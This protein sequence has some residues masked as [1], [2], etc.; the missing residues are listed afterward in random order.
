MAATGIADRLERSVGEWLYKALLEICG[1]VTGRDEDNRGVNVSIESDASL[2]S[3]RSFLKKISR[4]SISFPNGRDFETVTAQPQYGKPHDIEVKVAIKYFYRQLH[5]SA[6]RAG[7]KNALDRQNDDKKYITIISDLGL[8]REIYSARELGELIAITMEKYANDD[9]DVDNDIKIS[10]NIRS[11]RNGLICIVTRERALVLKDAG[12]LQCPVRFCTKWA[13]GEKGMWWHQRKEHNAEH[14][15]AVNSACSISNCRAIVVFNPL[16]FSLDMWLQSSTEGCKKEDKDGFSFIKDGD[17]EGLKELISEGKF[18]PKSTLD[19]NGSGSVLWA[20]GCGDLRV[21]RYLIEDC[22]CDPEEEQRGKRSFSA[23]RPLHWAARNGHYE[24]VK[25]LVDHC[26]VNLDASTKDGTTA[27]CWASWQGQTRIMQFL[28]NSGCDVHKK[29]AF[30][31][32]AVQWAAQGEIDVEG[33]EFMLSTKCDFLL[34]NSNG[35]GCVHKAAQR[36]R[37]VCKWLFE[38]PDEIPLGILQVGPDAE[39]LCPSDLAGEFL[40]KYCFSFIDKNFQRA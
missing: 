37:N 23:R 11:D 21:I 38:H 17:L 32:N 16:K 22:G 15:D 6:R 1:G 28:Y 31:C 26:K 13:K 8:E 4:G 2:E 14:I 5:L 35:H 39:G 40:H 10:D 7:L 33:M 9:D 30:G 29:N 20:A 24:V 12:R 36:G 34:I 27:F 18:C 25:Y 3:H 19:R